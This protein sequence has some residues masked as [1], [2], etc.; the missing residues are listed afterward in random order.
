[1]ALFPQFVFSLFR[2]G[3]I[4][5]CKKPTLRD[6]PAYAK[7][8][9]NQ[10][11]SFGQPLRFYSEPFISPELTTKECSLLYVLAEGYTPPFCLL[12]CRINEEKQTHF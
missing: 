7:I 12:V 9:S 8:A 3:L 11:R 5:I 6:T 1:M 4:S 2:K 10:N